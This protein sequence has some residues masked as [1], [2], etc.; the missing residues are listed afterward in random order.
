M[1]NPR[2]RGPPPARPTGDRPDRRRDRR[3]ADPGRDGKATES[4]GGLEPRNQTLGGRAEPARR[5]ARIG[6]E[7]MKPITAADTQSRSADLVA[8]NIG[9]I[10]DLFPEAV[11]EGKIDFGV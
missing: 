6:R 2:G 3:P 9:R 4:A 8:D 1:P 7:M 10:A 11:T 5:P